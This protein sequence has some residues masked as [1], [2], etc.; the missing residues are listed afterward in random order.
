MFKLVAQSHVAR[1]DVSQD[2]VSHTITLRSKSHSRLPTHALQHPVTTITL[3]Q[4]WSLPS[5]R[6]HN[7]CYRLIILLHCCNGATILAK[8]VGTVP[9]MISQNLF[10][11]RSTRYPGMG[12]LLQNGAGYWKPSFLF[13]HTL[14]AVCLGQVS[15][16]STQC[17]AH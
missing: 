13:H 17:S 6:Y 11:I 2:W 8:N 1:P 14:E 10:D 4:G 15:Y 16:G 3:I 12:C 7:S 9:P 5:Y